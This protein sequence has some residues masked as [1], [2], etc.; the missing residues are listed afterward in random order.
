MP[1]SKI[2]KMAKVFAEFLNDKV[3]EGRK[4]ESAILDLAQKLSQY[5]TAYLADVF[6]GFLQKKLDEGM[7]RRGAFLALAKTFPEHHAAY[8]EARNMTSSDIATETTAQTAAAAK[9]FQALIDAKVGAGKTARDA[10]QL[11]AVKK[12]ALFRRLDEVAQLPSKVS[13]QLIRS[14]ADQVFFVLKRAIPFFLKD[15]SMQQNTKSSFPKPAA[16]VGNDR[17][18][19][20]TVRWVFEAHK[21]YQFTFEEILSLVDGLDSHKLHAAFCDVHVDGGTFAQWFSRQ[22]PTPGTLRPDFVAL[23]RSRLIA[24]G[25]TIATLESPDV[26]VFLAMRHF[27]AAPARREDEARKEK[28]TAERTYFKIL[29][30]WDDQQPT[31]ELDQAAR[32]LQRT[33]SQVE[34]DLAIIREA[35]R[36]SALHAQWTALTEAADRLR[37]LARARPEFFDRGIIPRLLVV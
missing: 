19:A 23:L 15:V 33:A 6:D 25:K 3:S 10:A 8:L 36:L 30:R 18:G 7:D 22:N 26:F 24:A 32:V 17:D 35:Q 2:K 31:A 11:L 16:V 13:W 37:D 14:T 21:T 28:E 34:K 29:C 1:T 20:I 4:R 12:P 5:H 27:W 9:E